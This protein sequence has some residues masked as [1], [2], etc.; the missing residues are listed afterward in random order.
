M[1]KNLL[2]RI[3]LL[4]LPGFF[5][6]SEPLASPTW[7]FRLDP[8]EGYEFT[9]GDGKSR[10]SFR[11]AQGAALDLAVYPG[12]TGTGGSVRALAEDVHQRLANRGEISY[13]DYHNKPAALLSLE[14]FAGGQAYTG[15]GLCVE[16]ENRE[17]VSP[18]GAISGGETSSG[19]ES[20]PAGAGPPPL[21][22]ALAY[23]PAGRGELE[24]FHL[25]ALDSVAPAGT[26]RRR[27]G[28]VTEFAYPRGEREKKP[29]AGSGASAFVRRN[30]AEGAQA[31]VDREFA[32]LRRSADS[33][34][35]KEAWIRFYRAI[36]RDSFDRLA[37]AAFMLERRWNAPDLS[38]GAAAAAAGTPAGNRN[39][40]EKALGWV[41]SFAYERDL[42]GSDFINLVSAAFEGRGDCD[43]RALLW[44]II[45]EQAGIPGAIMVSREYRHAMGLADL[46]GAG[47]RFELAGKRWL[48]AETTAP[49]ALGLI[50]EQ[51]S[52]IEQWIGVVFE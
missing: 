46:P 4:L 26:D 44:A 40:A 37:D 43:S 8:P 21:L 6:F 47:A 1:K 52:D 51:S 23:G 35:W 12:K 7:G 5:A 48:T 10:F 41:Q 30:D 38:A 17:D 39:L 49:V 9:G 19:G 42:L 22:L 11:S 24:V 28:P 36:Y 20:S 31:L 16:L 50:G 25:S 34:L 3:A 15:W 18:G 13:F 14:F 32:V 27:P 2:L 33:P 45:L 29:L